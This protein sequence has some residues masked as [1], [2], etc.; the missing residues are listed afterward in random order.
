HQNMG[1]DRH[2]LYITDGD[3]NVWAIDR[4][5][6]ATIWKQTQLA[7]RYVTNPSL[8]HRYLLVADREGYIHWLDNQT[9]HLLGRVN[10]G[11]KVYQAPITGDNF[12]LVT[13]QNGTLAKVDL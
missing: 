4:Q 13:Q 7:N 5:T 6:G 3:H 2:A 11:E 8:Y 12:I 1:F 10:T 9:G